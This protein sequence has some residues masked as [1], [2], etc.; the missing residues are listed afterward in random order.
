MKYLKNN[1]AWSVIIY[2]VLSWWRLQHLISYLLSRLQRIIIYHSYFVC[3]PLPSLLSPGSSHPPPAVIT[4]PRAFPVVPLTFINPCLAF[5]V[6]TCRPH[7]LPISR[8]SHCTRKGL[9]CRAR[10]SHLAR[11]FLGSSAPDRMTASGPVLSCSVPSSWRH[12]RRPCGAPGRFGTLQRPSSA[13]AKPAIYPPEPFP[14][15]WSSV[16]VWNPAG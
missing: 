4:H 10:R 3:R 11:Q 8:V 12:P 13:L 5:F 9:A 16:S 1:K 6:N 15:H 14:F 2:S 7:G